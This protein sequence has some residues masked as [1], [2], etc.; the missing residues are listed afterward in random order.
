MFY[1]NVWEKI[2]RKINVTESAVYK[3][4]RKLYKPMLGLIRFAK[5]P[6]SK[7]MKCV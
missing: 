2:Y 7:I 6:I 1:C 5:Y 4:L 3:N